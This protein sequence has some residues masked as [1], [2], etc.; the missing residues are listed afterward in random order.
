MLFKK[1]PFLVELDRR[2][3]TRS[4]NIPF[5]TIILQLIKYATTLTGRNIVPNRRDSRI[6]Y[7]I[8]VLKTYNFNISMIWKYA[9]NCSNRNLYYY[10][11]YLQNKYEKRHFIRTKGLYN[12]FS[13]SYGLG[14]LFFFKLI[15]D[16]QINNSV[17]V[18]FKRISTEWH[19]NTSSFAR[20]TRPTLFTL[21]NIQCY[22]VF[23]NDRIVTSLV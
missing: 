13:N 6:K 4:L 22:G 16:I 12:V 23:E 11:V 18:L 9:S 3:L 8:I 7:H 14:F 1:L 2:W 21:W 20:L 19:W 15:F 10:N 5:I 17:C